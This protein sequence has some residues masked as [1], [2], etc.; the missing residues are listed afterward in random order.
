MSNYSGMI[1]DPGD[2]N[3]N[4]NPGCRDGGD[5]PVC[6]W[7]HVVSCSFLHVSI[8]YLVSPSLDPMVLCIRCSRNWQKSEASRGTP[9][10]PWQHSWPQVEVVEASYF[11]LLGQWPNFKLFGIT[12]LVGK[13]SRSNLFFSGSRTAE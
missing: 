6:H 8:V 13:I 3:A 7:A 4:Y 12:Y 10:F 9:T 2:K 5:L 11:T 1:I